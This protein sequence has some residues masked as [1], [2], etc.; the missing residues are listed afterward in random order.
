M[1]KNSLLLPR[2]RNKKNEKIALSY[3]VND[4]I[5]HV[6]RNPSNFVHIS[7]S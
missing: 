6:Y 4:H 7:S 1:Q 5:D 3:G 2:I